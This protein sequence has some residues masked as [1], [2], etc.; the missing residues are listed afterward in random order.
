MTKHVNTLVQNNRMN[1][2]RSG[3]EKFHILYISNLDSYPHDFP[4]LKHYYGDAERNLR[5]APPPLE[6]E[7][8]PPGDPSPDDPQDGQLGGRGGPGGAADPARNQTWQG[9]RSEYFSLLN[10][11]N[12]VYDSDPAETAL[13]KDYDA[14]WKADN[15]DPLPLAPIGSDNPDSEDDGNGGAPRPPRGGG[16]P[17]GWGPPR[18]GG[19]P[20]GGGPSGG[21]G[22]RD[23]GGNWRDPGG[24]WH[25]RGGGP[26][27][28][29]A[30][31]LDGKRRSPSSGVRKKATLCES[32]FE[33]SQKN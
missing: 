4:D 18:G 23:L 25:D 12:E 8:R 17:R 31:D 22:R 26:P 15:D 33:A 29:G 32:C 1:G 13:P 21:G 14:L 2:Q 9:P 5:T 27:G 28:G 10:A 16:P 30:R 6:E 11:N 3:S 19:P 7:S 20:G 24:S